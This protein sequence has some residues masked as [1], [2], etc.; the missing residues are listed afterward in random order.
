[1][2]EIRPR[3]WVAEILIGFSIVGLI[4]ISAII[5]ANDRTPDRHLTLLILASVLPLL[6]VGI[7]IVT[8]YHF[9]S[10]NFALA[11]NTLRK[12]TSP[13][14]APVDIPVTSAMIDR[15]KIAAMVPLAL[16]A[17]ISIKKDLLPRYEPPVTR[18]PIVNAKGAVVYVIHE[19]TLNKYVA[20][21]AANPAAGVHLDSVSL[22]SLLDDP[23]GE[24]LESFIAVPSYLSLAETKRRMDRK[25]NC[26]DAFVTETGDDR[27]PIIG[28][29]T[30]TRVAEFTRA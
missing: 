16:A 13:A 23:L 22:Q 10:S 27:D 2:E 25:P 6:A 20:K 26:K 7:G 17:K 28:W 21:I 3:G 12:L 8:A 1:M 15:D 19:S 4:V 11:A 9:A 29:V 14:T 30:D 5:V 18:I 24:L